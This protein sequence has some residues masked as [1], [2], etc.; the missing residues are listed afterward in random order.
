MAPHGLDMATALMDAQQLCLL[1]HNL[2][3]RMQGKSGEAW[4]ASAGEHDHSTFCTCIK[5]SQV[6]KREHCS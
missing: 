4:E 5:P 2:H 6:F 1:A 3:I